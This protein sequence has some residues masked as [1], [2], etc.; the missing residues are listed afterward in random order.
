[1]KKVI[2]LISF[3]IFLLIFL[4]LVFSYLFYLDLKNEHD[5]DFESFISEFNYKLI[6]Q[7]NL[8]IFYVNGNNSEKET[9]LVIQ[10]INNELYKDEFIK[11]SFKKGKVSFFICDYK[12]GLEGGNFLNLKNKFSEIF[13]NFLKICESQV[14]KGNRLVVFS[15]KTGAL[16]IPCLAGNGVQ[17]VIFYNVEISP[18]KQKKGVVYFLKKNLIDFD[19]GLEKLLKNG[20]FEKV[21]LFD[22]DFLK[23]NTSEKLL[24]YISSSPK[25]FFV[26]KNREKFFNFIN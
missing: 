17:K 8:N 25:E 12:R 24:F 26:L 14:S 5:N 18:F 13:R 2:I 22:K 19:F 23:V 3:T 21:F 15:Y 20:K 1:M 6:P 10:D 4:K 11:Y 16:F 9:L 7:K